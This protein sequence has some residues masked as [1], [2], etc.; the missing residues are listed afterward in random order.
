MINA[1]GILTSSFLLNVQEGIMQLKGMFQIIDWK[2]SIEKSFDAGGKLTTAI[3]S[4][5]YSGDIIGKSEVTFQMNY[6][7]NGNAVLSGL[8]SLW[9]T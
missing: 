7:T 9:E 2:E 5:I 1:H 3:V 4:L 8:S 6:E